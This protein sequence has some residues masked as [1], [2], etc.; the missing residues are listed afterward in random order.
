MDCFCLPRGIYQNHFSH[1][2]PKDH[3]TCGNSIT[4]ITATDDQQKSESD[5]SGEIQGR[6]VKLNRVNES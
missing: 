3:L 5:H 6:K 4:S 1:R 2:L